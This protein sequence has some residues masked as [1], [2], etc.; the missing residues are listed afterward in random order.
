MLSS[1]Y[2]TTHVLPIVQG[3]LDAEHCK[4][5]NVGGAQATA[6][7]HR[8]LQLRYP[9][10]FAAINLSRAEVNLFVKKS[11]NFATTKV[12]CHSTSSGPKGDR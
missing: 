11:V 3:R 2:Q 1:G 12:L 8:L 5:V 6:Y 9:V 10:H 4:R 7:L